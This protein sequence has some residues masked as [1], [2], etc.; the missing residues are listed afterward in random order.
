MADIIITFAKSQNKELNRGNAEVPLAQG[1]SFRSEALAIGAA[2]TA[3]TLAAM[4]N[5]N[6]VFLAPQADCWIDIDPA[7]TAVVLSSAGTATGKSIPLTGGGEYQFAVKRGS[8]V[9]VIG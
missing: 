6:V 7:P 1:E 4:N 9:A 8:K 3:S 5:E 2:S